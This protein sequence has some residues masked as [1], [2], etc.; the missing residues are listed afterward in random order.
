MEENLIS[1]TS[2][3]GRSARTLL[4]RMAADEARAERIRLLKEE[5]P[6][7]TWQAIADH[8]GVTVRAA[9][10]WGSSGSIAYEN[11][12][13]LAQL[14]DNVDAEYIMRGRPPAASS[15]P[16]GQLDRIEEGIRGLDAK[17]DQLLGIFSPS[18]QPGEADAPDEHDGPLKPLLDFLRQELADQ[19]ADSQ[20]EPR[21][22]RGK[23]A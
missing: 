18:A 12:K 7:L 4:L 8:V 20:A 23:S 10:A 17:V 15:A 6:E 16:E 9:Q 2:P 11:A 19:P 1:A 14:F 3:K 21:R 5:H 13:A 22:S